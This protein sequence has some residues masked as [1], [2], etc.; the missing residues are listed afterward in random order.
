MPHCRRLSDGPCSYRAVRA[1]LN[2][3]PAIAHPQCFSLPTKLPKRDRT[4]FL[5]PPRGVGGRV[6]V[7][8]TCS[9]LIRAQV[10]PPIMSVTRGRT[11]GR[12][13]PRPGDE[14]VQEGAEP[15]SWWRRVWG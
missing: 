3:P 1:L 10:R 12:A 11:R 9:D 8:T 13:E 14:E 4:N 6:R 15:R 7:P 2:L 5:V